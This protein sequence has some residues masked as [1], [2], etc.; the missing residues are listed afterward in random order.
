MKTVIS[1]A[2]ASDNKKPTDLVTL[3]DLASRYQKSVRHMRRIIGST[4]F[5]KPFRL[6]ISGKTNYWHFGDIVDWEKSLQVED[7]E[8]V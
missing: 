1:I 6:A 5:P 2:P 3:A 4:D 7:N 8:A